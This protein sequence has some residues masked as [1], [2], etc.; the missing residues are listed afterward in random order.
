[1]IVCA[2]KC[3]KVVGAVRRQPWIVRGPTTSSLSRSSSFV[4]RVHVAEPRDYTD[5][6]R[7]KHPQTYEDVHAHQSLAAGH[8]YMDQA[9]RRDAS[10][11]SF[12]PSPPHVRQ[13]RYLRLPSG[14]E[15]SRRRSRDCIHHSVTDSSIAAHCAGMPRRIH[16]SLG[17]AQN[18]NRAPNAAG[19]LNPR[20]ELLTG[21]AKHVRIDHRVGGESLMPILSGL[22]VQ[23]A[24]QKRA[25]NGSGPA[26]T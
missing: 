7:V 3:V 1:M 26:R 4:S 23:P 18:P 24:T 12:R 25:W 19:F 14:L 15:R 6:F 11:V 21:L 22:S 8:V 17:N 10:R 16:M 13:G 20:L 5:P 2:L 9:H